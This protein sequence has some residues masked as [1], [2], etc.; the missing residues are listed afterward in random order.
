MSTIRLVFFG[1]SDF[2]VPSLKALAKDPRFKILS[3]VTQPNRAVGRHATVT[4]PAIKT[5]ALELK[6]SV[7]QYEKVK[8]TEVIETIKALNADLAIVISFGQLI[9][10]ALLDVFPLGAVNVHGSLLPKYRGASPIQAAIREGD[11]QTGVTI[12]LLDKLMDHGPILH[13][14]PEPIHPTDTASSLHDRLAEL[15]A[16]ALPETLIGYQ[17]GTIKPVEQDHA[18]AT[19]VSLL[20]RE[21]GELKPTEK[22][23]RALEHLVRAYTP[24]PGTFLQLDQQKLK[25]KQ[26]VIGAQ[27][28]HQPGTKTIGKDGQPILICRDGMELILTLVQPEGKREMS[29]R[30]FLRGH[31]WH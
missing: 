4:P 30:D 24:W 10:Q 29:G 12:M 23:A 22:T 6:L 5:A 20:S 18:Q 17:N 8:D 26:V 21:A 9:P 14:A 1:T 11:S 3:V 25:I 28:T 13:L 15:G 27:T 2:A 19:H 31:V 16:A 7:L